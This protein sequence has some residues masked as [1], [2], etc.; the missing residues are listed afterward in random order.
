MLE[1]LKKKIPYF[2]EK[3]SPV[4]ADMIYMYSIYRNLSCKGLFGP[5][6]FCKFKLVMKITVYVHIHVQGSTSSTF[7]E[8]EPPVKASIYAL[9][10]L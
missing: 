7:S 5:Y 4:K 6:N 9:D 8:Q 3:A 2:P 1:R 10:V